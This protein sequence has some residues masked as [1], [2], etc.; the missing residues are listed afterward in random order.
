MREKR[1][2]AEQWM[3]HRMLPDDLRKWIRQYEQSKWQET[4]GVKEDSLIRNLPKDLRRDIN[5]H[6]C[7]SLLTRARAPQPLL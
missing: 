4:R 7:W 1:Q 2:D 6:V 3:F 5:R